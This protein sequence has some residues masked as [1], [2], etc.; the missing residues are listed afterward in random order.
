MCD[1]DK[2]VTIIPIGYEL[3]REHLNVY[4]ELEEK[5]WTKKR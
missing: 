2:L 1:K 5:G 3:C 4:F